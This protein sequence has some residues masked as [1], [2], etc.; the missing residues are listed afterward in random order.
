MNI[1][2]NDNLIIHNIQIDNI[3]TN[4]KLNFTQNDF[5]TYTSNNLFDIRS[6]VKS[7]QHNFIIKDNTV[8]SIKLPFNVVSNIYMKQ[9]I[10]NIKLEDRRSIDLLT[11]LISTYIKLSAN[12]NINDICISV[13][14]YITIR[15]R[16]MHEIKDMTMAQMKNMSLYNFYFTEN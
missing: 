11:A 8:F 1:K 16:K 9:S 4:I 10:F 7:K 15:A 6:A 14:D 5:N 12:I 2:I 13:N 3:D